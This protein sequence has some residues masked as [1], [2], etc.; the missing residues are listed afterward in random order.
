MTT[1]QDTQVSWP[2][3]RVIKVE[4]TLAAK[5]LV[6][7]N[8]ADAIKKATQKAA[9]AVQQLSIEFPAWM[10]GESDRLDKVRKE[11]AD[12]GFSAERLDQLFTCAHDIK[13]QAPTYGYPVA[14]TI[15]KLL[16]D[17]IENAPEGVQIPLAV[18]DQHVDTIRAVVRQNLKGEGNAQTSNIIEGLLV[19]DHTTLRKLKA[20]VPAV[21]AE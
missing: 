7:G 10:Q 8:P 19:L 12:K 16:A 9:V 15:G 18:I 3:Y 6:S 5:A 1:A 13:G 2:E 20:S 11:L 17:L 4:N 14:G 21:A